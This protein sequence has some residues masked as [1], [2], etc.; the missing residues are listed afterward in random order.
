MIKT[1]IRAALVASVALLLGLCV[2]S[3]A[4]ATS[5]PAGNSLQAAVTCNAWGVLNASNST[6]TVTLSD[7]GVWHYASPGEQLG[8]RSWDKIRVPWG[9]D[10]Q[11]HGNGFYP[12]RIYKVN[13]QW[14][15]PGDWTCSTRPGNYWWVEVVNDGD[16]FE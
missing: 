16:P 5:Q 9:S 8:A 4:S 15:E 1:R 3:P 6:A 2:A 7:S 10:I 11:L 13:G 14:Y 12:N